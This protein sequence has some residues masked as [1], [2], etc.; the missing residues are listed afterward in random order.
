MS[1]SLFEDFRPSKEELAPGAVVL[2]EFLSEEQSRQLVALIG[3]IATVSPFRHMAVRGGRRMSVAMT[4]C[5]ALGWISDESGYRY[6]RLDPL[7]GKP[8]P[9]MPP[10]FLELASRAASEAAF[11]KFLPDACLINRYTPGAQMGLHQDRDEKDAGAPIVS[12]SL[13]LPAT[14]LF[15]G[16]RRSERPHRIPLQSGDVVVFGGP[17]R[18]AYHGIG[19]LASGEHPLSGRSRLNLTFRKTGF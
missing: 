13:G 7:T 12:V 18:L 4:S 3:E 15:G 1:P 11:T 6:S 19:K 5:G 14:F 8:W 2:H 10:E 16:S 17:S 9:E